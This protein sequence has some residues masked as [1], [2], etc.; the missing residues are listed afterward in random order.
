MSTRACWCG[1]PFHEDL[2]D[3]CVGE[4][5][6]RAMFGPPSAA[7]LISMAVTAYGDLVSMS[8]EGDEWATAFIRENP[9]PEPSIGLDQ[10]MLSAAGMDVSA[11]DI[12][13][14][15]DWYWPD[16]SEWAVVGG[17]SES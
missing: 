9:I 16:R 11:D 5:F 17:G 2:V 12:R 8:L 7:A 6:L 10:A 1:R 4:V 13:A 14:L 3:G 15:R